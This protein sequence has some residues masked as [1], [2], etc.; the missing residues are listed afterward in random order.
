MLFF[1]VQW[2][3]DTQLSLVRNYKLQTYNKLNSDCT[4]NF[5]TIDHLYPINKSLVY[6]YI[7]IYIYIYIRIYMNIYAYICK[8]SWLGLYKEFPNQKHTYIYIPVMDAGTSTYVPAV[9]SRDINVVFNVE[10]YWL[11]M[12]NKKIAADLIMRP[13]M[14]WIHI[15]YFLNISNISISYKNIFEAEHK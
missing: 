15:W 6:V 12:K 4:K 3:L 13:K 5:P 2:L 7:C 1:V 14:S 11:T 10:I 9:A 8:I